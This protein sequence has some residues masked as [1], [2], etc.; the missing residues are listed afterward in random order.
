MCVSN[1]DKSVVKILDPPKDA[2]PGDIVKIEGQDGVN[3]DTGAKKLLKVMEQTKEVLRTD[4]NGVAVF[5][6]KEMKVNG[7]IMNN[8]VKE[9]YIS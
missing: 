1:Q 6:G 7:K 3:W 4:K 9:G 5:E 2:K 8:E